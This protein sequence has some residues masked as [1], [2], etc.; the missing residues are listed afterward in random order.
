MLTEW[1]GS[2]VPPVTDEVG[3]NLTYKITNFLSSKFLDIA[4]YNNNKL[5]ANLTHFDEGYN[6]VVTTCKECEEAK[7]Q[8]HLPAGGVYKMCYNFTN[9]VTW[10][11]KDDPLPGYEVPN[12]TQYTHVPSTQS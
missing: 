2:T 10:T 5:V 9:N 1:P 3:A 4:F 11:M 6:V 7:I 8:L 12:C